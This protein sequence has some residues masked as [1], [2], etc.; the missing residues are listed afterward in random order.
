MI[1]HTDL[2]EIRCV[3]RDEL[4]NLSSR[5]RRRWRLWRQRRGSRVSC[6]G[7]HGG[8]YL[9]VKRTLTT[10]VDCRTVLDIVVPTNPCRCA[11]LNMVVLRS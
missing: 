10:G 9:D 4:C 5:Q 11:K 1:S 2:I 8:D 3:T 6:F 7:V